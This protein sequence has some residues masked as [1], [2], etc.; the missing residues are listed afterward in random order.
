MSSKLQTVKGMHELLPDDL[1]RIELV[2][3]I[4]IKTAAR[5]GFVRVQTP[6]LEFVQTYEST[7]KFPEQRCYTLVD[8]A[9]RKLV[10]R[11]DPDAPI[12]RLAITH[13]RRAPKPIKLV[14]CGSIFRAWNP[15]RREFRMFSAHT[16]GIKEASADAEILRVVVDVVDEVGFS[17]Y[18]VQFNNLQIF[19]TIIASEGGFSESEVDHILYLVRFAPTP[20]AV[21]KVL[22]AAHLQS[23]NIT[24]ILSLLQIGDNENAAYELLRGLSVEFPSLT[25]EVEKIVAFSR[26]L[27]SQ[28]IKNSR[29]NVTNLHGTGFYSGITYQLSP[30]HGRKEIGDGG[31]YDHMAQRMQSEEMP[32]TGM[33]LGI[34]RFIELMAENHCPILNLPK[35]KSIVISYE[36]D[37]LALACRPASR[38][39]RSSG[40][41]VEEDLASRDFSKVVR[42]ATSKQYRLVAV[43]NRVGLDRSLN[44]KVVYLGED[45]STSIPISNID[46]LFNALMRC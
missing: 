33:G 39:L 31:R 26:A 9:G 1:A 13:F 7:S 37:A 43:L 5:Y 27:G 36:D 44:L 6:V 8:A 45:R 42:Y 3:S 21:V 20:E 30:E 15:R 28:G 12:T 34:E 11:S 38:R 17:G 14:F 19:R 40:W 10:L 46:D 4:F 23:K 41:I 2:E 35:S 32:A 22:E 16:F 25:P 18:R 24:A 29:L